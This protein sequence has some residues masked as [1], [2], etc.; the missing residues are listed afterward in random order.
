MLLACA[1][2]RTKTRMEQVRMGSCCPQFCSHCPCGVVLGSVAC[3]VRDE[4]YNLTFIPS[5]AVVRCYRVVAVH[6]W[7]LKV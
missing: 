5:E 2:S 3:P 1:D 6:E 7:V 4:K